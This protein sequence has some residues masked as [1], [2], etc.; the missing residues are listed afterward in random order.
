[1]CRSS[2]MIGSSTLASI[3]YM[4]TTL[5]PLSKY[6]SILG[7]KN[8]DG[9]TKRITFVLPK[10]NNMQLIHKHTGKKITVIGHEKSKVDGRLL[11]AIKGWN[12]NERIDLNGVTTLDGSAVTEDMFV[13]KKTPLQERI[14]RIMEINALSK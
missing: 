9:N 4:C 10:P 3:V 13:V 12:K 5:P 11:L 14:D 1:M 8:L 2:I 6:F 7:Q